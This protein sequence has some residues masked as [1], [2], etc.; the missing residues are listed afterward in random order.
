MDAIR[1][2]LVPK[3]SK[4]Y[5]DIVLIKDWT[6]HTI[7]QEDP[8]DGVPAH[9]QEVFLLNESNKISEVREIF[10][11]KKFVAKTLKSGVWY[12]T[13]VDNLLKIRRRIHG[14]KE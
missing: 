2:R 6:K 14:N 9:P 7:M 1:T 3:K 5:M 12:E 13:D 4:D 10:Y 8:L 11:R